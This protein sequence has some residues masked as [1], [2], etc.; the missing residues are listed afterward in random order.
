VG[1]STKEKE[2]KAEGSKRK[3]WVTKKGKER[4]MDVKRSNLLR[5]LIREEKRGIEG[6]MSILQDILEC[7]EAKDSGSCLGT[8]V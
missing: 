1:H 6:K 7:L 8:H 4:V 3:I 5:E 2:S